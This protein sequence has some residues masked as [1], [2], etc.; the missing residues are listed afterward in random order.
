MFPLDTL[1][2]QIKYSLYHVLMEQSYRLIILPSGI[3]KLRLVVEHLISFIFQWFA[4]FIRCC[5]IIS[6]VIIRQDHGETG[7]TS[8]Y[9]P[10]LQKS[11]SFSLKTSKLPEN[12]SVKLLHHYKTF[13]Q[14]KT[15]NEWLVRFYDNWSF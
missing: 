7:R 11:V 13:L 1:T 14:P 4:C 2:F 5:I 12:V 3:F 15:M 10:C 6:N 9:L 8:S